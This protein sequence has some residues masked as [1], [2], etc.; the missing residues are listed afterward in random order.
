[1]LAAAAAAV[2][3]AVNN[4]ICVYLITVQYHNGADPM[5]IEWII[6]QIGLVSVCVCEPKGRGDE[7]VYIRLKTFYY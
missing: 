3:A 2:T 1:M 6:F 7:N 4:L 5:C